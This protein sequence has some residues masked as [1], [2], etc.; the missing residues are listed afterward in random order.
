MRDYKITHREEL[1]GEYFVEAESE[2]DAL[3]FFHH[4]CREGKIDFGDLEMV[5]SDDT[6]SVV[7]YDKY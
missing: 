6:A 7:E 5:D 2:E 4:L 1:V 3:E